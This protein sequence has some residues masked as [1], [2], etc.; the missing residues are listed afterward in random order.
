MNDKKRELMRSSDSDYSTSVFYTFNFRD[1][2]TYAFSVVITDFS[3]WTP[4]QSGPEKFS[5]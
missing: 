5:T 4:L 2:R 1:S 3:L